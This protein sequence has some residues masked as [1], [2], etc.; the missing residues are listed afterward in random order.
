MNKLTKEYLTFLISFVYYAGLIGKRNTELKLYLKK[1]QN[2]MKITK[3][4]L[5]CKCVL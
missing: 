3:N 4:S 5:S 2:V 1:K